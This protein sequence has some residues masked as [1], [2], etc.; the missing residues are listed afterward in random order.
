[1]RVTVRLLIQMSLASRIGFSLVISPTGEVLYDLIQ[2]V[3]ELPKPNIPVEV[4][5][6]KQTRFNVKV[7]DALTY[8]GTIF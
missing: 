1:M 3:W 5:T 7:S 6:T 4:C 2:R 8:K